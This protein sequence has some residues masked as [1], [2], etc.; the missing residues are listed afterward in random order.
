MGIVAV[1]AGITAYLIVLDP[2]TFIP[3]AGF[4]ILSASIPATVVAGAVYL[5]LS[6][7][8]AKLRDGQRADAQGAE[9]VE[10]EGREDRTSRV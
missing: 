10:R 4:E 7:L 8:W 1:A 6:L 9:R 2:V 3:G 5:V